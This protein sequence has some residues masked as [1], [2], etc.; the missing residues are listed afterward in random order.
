[1]R[2]SCPNCDARYEVPDEVMPMAG[3]DVQCSNCGRTWFQHHPDNMPL[4]E[5][6]DVADAPQPDAAPVVEPSEAVEPAAPPS[7]ALPERR[8]LDPSVADILQQ[9]AE[10][11]LA[12]RKNR[13]SQALESQPDLGLDMGE[14]RRAPVPP[15]PSED[16]TARQEAEKRAQDAK[17]R[18][19]RMRGE[20]E[21]DAQGAAASA[22]MSSRRELLPD[23]DEIN[24]TLRT[25]SATTA[26]G[27]GNADGRKRPARK[28]GFRRG[29]SFMLLIFAVLALVYVFAPQIAQRV[30]AIDP[31]LNSFVTWV[32]QLRLAINTQM[33]G[34][35]RWLDDVASQ[36]GS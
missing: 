5:A 34:L 16:A 2:L 36:S 21:L 20:Q 19:A 23:I 25:D 6:E 4:E 15:L 12:A 14:E 8:K 18:M 32:D 7:T 11:E 31:L 28:A 1:M 26:T 10:A 17:R 29:F 35:L 13:Q 24:S 30:P 22:A 33:Q 9:E 3:R 27:K